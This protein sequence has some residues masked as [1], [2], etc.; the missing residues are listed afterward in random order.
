[1]SIEGIPLE[2]FSALP[3]ADINSTTQSCQR[4]A[5]LLFLSDNRKQDSATTT[6]HSKRLIALLKDKKLL[7][8]YLSKIWEN[9]VAMRLLDRKI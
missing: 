4:H 1:M 2:N 7:T 5:V 8:T 6:E 9:T 3:K